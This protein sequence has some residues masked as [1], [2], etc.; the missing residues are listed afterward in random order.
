[1]RIKR[2]RE[3]ERERKENQLLL[4]CLHLLLFTVDAAIAEKMAVIGFLLMGIGCG[5]SAFAIVG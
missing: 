2:E 1:M 3:R 5:N 4:I